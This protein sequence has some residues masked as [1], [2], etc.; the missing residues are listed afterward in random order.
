MNICQKLLLT[1][2]LFLSLSACK[3]EEVPTPTTPSQMIIHEIV[4][5]SWPIMHDSI[6]WDDNSGPDI[7]PVIEKSTVKL[8]V[9]E[10]TYTDC[11]LG[12]YYVYGLTAGLPKNFYNLNNEITLSLYDEENGLDTWMGGLNF[13]PMAHHVK[14]NE[15]FTLKRDDWEVELF[16]TWVY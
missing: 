15:R 5:K 16:V 14:G 6:T 7:Y 13:T 12:T 10:V 3:K 4:V 8:F 9:S 1:P 2:L 11:L